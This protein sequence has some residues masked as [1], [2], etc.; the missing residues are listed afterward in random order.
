MTYSINATIK[1]NSAAAIAGRAGRMVRR[2]NQ[3]KVTSGRMTQAQLRRWVRRIEADARA[4][5][6]DFAHWEGVVRLL[7]IGHRKYIAKNLSPTQRRTFAVS[8]PTE[9]SSVR[10]VCEHLQVGPGDF[11]VEVCRP[12]SADEMANPF[13]KRL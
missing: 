9:A 7:M 12:A 2:S 11:A 5:P 6:V 13:V 8:A 3:W 4:N 10:R 1:G